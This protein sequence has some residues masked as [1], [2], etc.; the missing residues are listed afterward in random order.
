MP[1]TAAQ[2]KELR[3]ITGEGMMECKRALEA[4]EGNIELA[5]EEMRKSGRAKAA[6]KAGRTAAEGRVVV[7]C[8]DGAAAIAE[9][10]CETDFVGRDDNFVEFANI[11]VQRVLESSM[12]DVQQL[13]QLPVTRDNQMTIEQQRHAL[14]AK[15]GENI[16]VRRVAV[17]HSSGGILGV[18]VHHHRIGVIVNLV[19]GDQALAQDLA[20]HIAASNPEVI[21]PQDVS[22]ERIAKEKEIFAAQV[23]GSGKPAEIVE[24]MITGRIQKFLDEV[25]LLGQAFVKDPNISVGKLLSSANASVK[26]FVRYEVG[27]GI[28]K[29]TT[30]F[31]AEVMAQVQGQ[32]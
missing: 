16:N 32:G 10:N 2:V 23:A 14:V 21:L 15:V 30:D 12:T 31:V 1:I 22:P 3:E 28:E 18:Y 24:K 17:V 13:L 11:V 19:G 26:S 5:I 6:K 9:V 8:F 25:S 27:E 4:A 7:R 20:M 29:T